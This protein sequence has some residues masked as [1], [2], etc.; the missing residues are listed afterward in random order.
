VVAGF[1]FGLGF[2]AMDPILRHALDYYV[3]QA[4]TMLQTAQLTGAQRG[5]APVDLDQIYAE[6]CELRDAIEKLPAGIFYLDNAD[7]PYDLQAI[8]NG[9]GTHVLA[10]RTDPANATSVNLYRYEADQIVA[11]ATH[12]RAH[13]ETAKQRGGPGAGLHIA[14]PQGEVRRRMAKAL[15]EDLK[16][17]DVK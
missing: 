1:S 16:I 9:M 5:N 6:F 3:E 2:P 17:Q 14:L 4:S 11:R 7:F 15:T 13:L 12:L 8:L 10:W